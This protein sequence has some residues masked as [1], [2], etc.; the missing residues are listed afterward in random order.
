MESLQSGYKAE[1]AYTERNEISCLIS[2]THISTRLTRLINKAMS[3]T[4]LL[5]K[6]AINGQ[7]LSLGDFH[8]VVKVFW[9][10]LFVRTAAV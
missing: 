2:H 4:P 6:D 3:R 5:D 1:V 9:K 8:L 10:R 7:T